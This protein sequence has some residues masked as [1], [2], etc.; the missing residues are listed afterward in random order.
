MGTQL[1]NYKIKELGQE[2]LDWF[3][4]NAAV[5]MLTDELGRDELIDIDTL[6]DLSFKVIETKTAYVVMK[7]EEYCGAIAGMLVPNLFNPKYVSLVELFW[8]VLPEYRTGRAGLLLLRALE[9]RANEL[10]VD[11][12]LSILPHSEVEINTLERMGFVFEELGFRK[13]Y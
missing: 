10:G 13:V 8:Y 6:R 12:T 2:D 3:I 11:L 7:G 9:D 1:P 4:P 5:R